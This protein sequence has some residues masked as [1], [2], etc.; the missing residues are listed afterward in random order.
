MM[1]AAIIGCLCK[2]PVHFTIRSDMFKNRIFRF[3]LRFLNGI[4][5]YRITEDRNRL[6]ENFTTFDTCR[7]ILK[8]KGIILIFSEGHTLQDWKLKSIKSGTYR[9]VA[10]ALQ[11]KELQR[12]L[13]VVP[14]GLTYS[15]YAH[16]AK[17]ILV[18]AA[19][20]FY[21]AALANDPTALP[22]KYLFNDILQEKLTPLVPGMTSEYRQNI[23]YWQALLTNITVTASCDA[24]TEQ[25]HKKGRHLS[26]VMIEATNNISTEPFYISRNPRSVIRA[27]C[28]LFL[29]MVPALAG[30]ILNAWYYVPVNAWCRKKTAG[31]IFFDS[32]LLGV[33][34]VTYPVYFL[35]LSLFL[36]YNTPVTAW[37]WILIIP[38]TGW[39]ALQAHVLLQ[40][41]TNYYN[42]GKQTIAE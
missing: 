23:L 18:H 35:I 37:L 40:S 33:T 31:S 9:I 29:A 41:I 36:H 42:Y 3:L 16:L 15:S 27:C 17:T 5:V 21:P 25:L 28:L 12:L 4:P 30:Y 26:N 1:D 10:H 32:L 2:N 13:Q 19:T 24:T 6:K 39:C 11:D 14:V 22:S 8:Q 7:E 38:F 20:P 34:T